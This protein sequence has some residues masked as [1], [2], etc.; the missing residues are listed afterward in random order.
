VKT[1]AA[2]LVYLLWLFNIIDYFTTDVLLQHGYTEGNPVMAWIIETHGMAGSLV[3]KLI[4][5]VIITEILFE[6]YEGNATGRAI[7]MFFIG[8]VGLNILYAFVVGNNLLL[9]AKI[10]IPYFT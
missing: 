7:R 5:L 10:A 9:Y 6:Y 1:F 3:F 4:F 8:M 2:V